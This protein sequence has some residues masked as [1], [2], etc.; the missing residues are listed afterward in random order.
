MA[1]REIS[2]SLKVLKNTKQ[3]ED[4]KDEDKITFKEY[5][6]SFYLRLSGYFFK[7]KFN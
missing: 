7:F 2:K 5:L 4:K 3:N 6:K 1:F